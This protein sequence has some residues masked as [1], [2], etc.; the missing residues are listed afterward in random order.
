MA[1][2][3][4]SRPASVVLSDRKARLLATPFR[5]VDVL[6]IGAAIAVS[7][8]G[9]LMIYSS[10]QPK[11]AAANMDGLYFVKRQALAILVGITLMFGV[12][13]VDYRKLRDLGIFVYVATIL[14]LLAVLSPLGHATKGA[15]ARFPL[16]GGFELQPSE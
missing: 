15:Q 4:R 7:M 14:G 10:T 5:H 9:L 11:L 12:M 16:P 6:L 1:T 2:V 13:A 8:L 3:A